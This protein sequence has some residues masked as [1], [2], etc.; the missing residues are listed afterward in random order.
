MI[1]IFR[2]A[3]DPLADE[4]GRRLGSS[5]QSLTVEQ[6]L[7]GY[8]ITHT[9]DEGGTE[10]RLLP[11][12]GAPPWDNV[13]PA[14]VINRVRQVPGGLL[15]L[16]GH[17]DSG[18]AEAEASALFWSILEGYGC[19]VY[20][21]PH[22]FAGFHSPVPALRWVD[23]ARQ[24]GLA[25]S[26]Y[27][28]TTEQA[29]LGRARSHMTPLTH[30]LLPG[31]GPGWFA[32]EPAGTRSTTW[33]CGRP[34]VGLPPGLSPQAIRGFA[35]ALGVFIAELTFITGDDGQSVL[36]GVD[37]H[38]DTLPAKAMD[39]LCAHLHAANAGGTTDEALAS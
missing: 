20:N 7:T 17:P 18:Y 21:A 11:R 33:L 29:R 8:R 22:L 26:A 25:T 30:S 32:D 14:I 4:L 10:T 6:L 5:A 15:A 28:M 38:P 2:H 35:A 19:P 27:V 34:V 31:Q 1:N 12:P 24:A 39:A 3:A 36:T 37:P 13:R 16:T 23:A 9:Q